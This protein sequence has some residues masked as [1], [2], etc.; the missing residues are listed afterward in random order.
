MAAE[1]RIRRYIHRTPVFSS[2]L[3]NAA[4]GT[5]VV[6]KA[7]NLQKI[8]AFKARGATNAVLS[9]SDADLS[10]GVVTHSSGNHG[11]AVAYAS[12]LVGTHATIVMP[13]S[14]SSVKVAAIESLGA[15]IVFCPQ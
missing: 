12:S 15:E 4:A 2:H 7:E 6:V 5:D 9:L 3:L 8:G 1:R 14:A 11:Q 13:E 10:R